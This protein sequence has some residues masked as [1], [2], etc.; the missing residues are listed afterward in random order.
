MIDHGKSLSAFVP[1]A[2]RARGYSSRRSP[3]PMRRYR[4]A[5]L[6]VV[7]S[8]SA[9]DWQ[10]PNKYEETDVRSYSYPADPSPAGSRPDGSG[11]RSYRPSSA[12]PQSP[13]VV[14]PQ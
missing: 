11:P 6:V 3:W 9:T 12:Q 8:I 2:S 13:L 10:S 1:D 4:C 7:A 14:E 5:D